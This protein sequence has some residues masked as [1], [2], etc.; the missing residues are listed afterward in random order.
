MKEADLYQKEEIYKEKL[1]D[2]ENRKLAAKALLLYTNK[3][4]KDNELRPKAFKVVE[5]KKFKKFANDIASLNLTPDYYK[6]K[7]YSRMSSAIK[8]NIRLVFKV[9]DFASTSQPLNEAIKFFKEYVASNKSFSDYKYEKIPT[10]FIPKK[11][12]K[13]IIIK[14]KVDKKRVLSVDADNY[15][16]ALYL[17]IEK[18]LDN[19]TVTVKDSFNYKAL[20][21][22]LVDS[23]LWK[24]DKKKLI[25]AVS[26]QLITTDFDKLMAT[27]EDLLDNRYKEINKRISEGEN[28]KIK[29][30]YNKKG[31]VL[32]WRLPYKSANDAT[33]NPFYDSMNLLKL[34]EVMRFTNH[35]VNFM[36]HF[37]HVIPTYVKTTANYSSVSAC[38]VAKGTGSDINRMKDISDINEQELISTYNNYVRY[39][40][41][42]KSCDEIINKIAQFQ[43]FAKYNLSDYGVHA[44]ID[45]QKLETKYNTIKARHSKKY[46]GLG[47]GVSALT[48]FGNCLPLCT[49]II[50]ANEHESYYLLDALKSNTSDV[51][52]SRISGDMHSVNR[53]NFALLHMFG[54]RFMPRFTKLDQKAQKNLVCFKDPKKYQRF[55]IKPNRKSNKELLK[56]EWDNILRIFVTLAMK[57]NTQSRIVRKLS[58]FK[59]NDTLKALIELDKIVMSLYILDYVDDEQMRKS[60]HRSLNRGESYHQ[61]R[62]AIAKVSGRKLAGRDEI[63]LVIHNESARFI[64]LCIIFYNASLLTSLY[65]FCLANNMQ[66][67]CKKITKLSPVAWQHISLVGKYEFNR[68]GYDV[69]N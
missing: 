1:K 21:D 30:K 45:G 13:Y 12:K 40:T 62:A 42:V 6:W 32:R 24:K 20:D 46:Y 49:K 53:V 58:S 55:T 7:Y 18:S 15:E 26:D 66:D 65:E 41:L 8:L 36:Q 4:V 60:V 25:E 27:F 22:E 68:D 50:G 2:I 44:S 16:F 43:I 52:I 39:E 3:K 47:K 23:E 5:E 57:K 33:N 54:Y 10:S 19:G 11:T 9:I 28:D 67:E 37:T 64:A 61:L 63:E 38:L 31:E 35:Q 34:E 56:K 14:T 51:E 59:S 17:E 48:L 29:I 69:V